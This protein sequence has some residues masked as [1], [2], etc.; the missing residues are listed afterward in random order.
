MYLKKK[1]F[2]T[3]V[4]E[5]L[6][7]YFLQMD[8]VMVYFKMNNGALRVINKWFLEDMMRNMFDLFKYTDM[9]Q[10]FIVLWM[11]NLFGISLLVNYLI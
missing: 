6:V 4:K 11:G 3:F 1:A 9:F 8:N 5:G 7:A 2:Q 10:C